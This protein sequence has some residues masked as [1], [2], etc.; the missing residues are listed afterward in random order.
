MKKKSEN[1]IEHFGK[2]SHYQTKQKIQ[3][4]RLRALT[5]LL[6]KFRTY[7]RLKTI[8]IFSVL[9]IAISFFLNAC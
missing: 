1:D 6:D 5:I 3:E 8:D 9:N 4:N 2:I 7:E